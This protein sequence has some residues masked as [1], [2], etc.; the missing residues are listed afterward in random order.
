MLEGG[1]RIT[2]SITFVRIPKVIFHYA[3]TILSVEGLP[4]SKDDGGMADNK[5]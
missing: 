5:A 1:K 2:D 4:E 3:L